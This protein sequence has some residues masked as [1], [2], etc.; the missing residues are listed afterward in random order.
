MKCL[1]NH[2]VKL[3]LKISYVDIIYYRLGNRSTLEFID[4]DKNPS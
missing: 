2:V 1:E 4:I 3:R